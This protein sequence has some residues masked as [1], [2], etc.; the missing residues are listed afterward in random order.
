MRREPADIWLHGLQGLSLDK[1]LFLVQTKH[2][3]VIRYEHTHNGVEE[4]LHNSN[5]T[6]T[7]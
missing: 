2:T 1:S 5:S 7:T 4:E 3:D 6:R